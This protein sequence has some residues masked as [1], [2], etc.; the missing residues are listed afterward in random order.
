[1]DTIPWLIIWIIL[2]AVLFIGEMLTVTFF[3]L[4]FAV[5][6]GVAAVAAAAGAPVWLQFV[7]LIVVSVL[8]LIVTRPLANKVSGKSKE[9][10][11]ASRLEGMRGVVIANSANTRPEAAGATIAGRRFRVLVDRDEWSAVN[12]AGTGATALPEGT[13]VEVL[14]VEGAHLVVLEASSGQGSDVR[15]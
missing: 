12:G 15:K 8:S 7:L 13:E 14:R 5:G 9:K 6:T 3:M 1:M 4:P 11:G 2:T 10:A